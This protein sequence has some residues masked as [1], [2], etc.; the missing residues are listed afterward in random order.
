MNKKSIMFSSV[1]N[2]DGYLY[3]LSVSVCLQSDC[4]HADGTKE[5]KNVIEY[6]TF[7]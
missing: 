1:M 4:L 3:L 5:G 2:R 7:C 6:L